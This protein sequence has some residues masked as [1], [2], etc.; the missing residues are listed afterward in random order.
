MKFITNKPQFMTGCLTALQSYNGLP[1][2]T[3]NS[4]LKLRLL[5]PSQ[6]FTVMVKCLPLLSCLHI[7]YSCLSPD[8]GSQLAIPPLGPSKIFLLHQIPAG[9]F[10]PR[11]F[12]GLPTPTRSFQP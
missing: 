4:V 8:T 5:Q 11:V 6:S 7:V 10:P 1:K 3:Y 12:S 9:L 2:A